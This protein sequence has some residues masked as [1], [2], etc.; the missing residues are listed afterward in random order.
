MRSGGD[1]L[2]LGHNIEQA[3]SEIR[4]DLSVGIEPHLAADRPK[5][6][7]AAVDDFMEALW[8]AIGIMLAVSFIRLGV[9][10]GAVVACSIPLV[11]A[12]VFVGM[13]F[14]GIDLQ[15]VSLG[16]LIIALGLLVDD[17]A[18][19]GRAL[20]PGL[21]A[22]LAVR[23]EQDRPPTRPTHTPIVALVRALAAPVQDISRSIRI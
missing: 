15:R 18:P 22:A 8:E 17:P 13:E 10:A 19:T 2:A 16:A 3:M 9:R 12:A 6:V 21:A 7:K 1:V 11:L 14:A 23:A 20:P 5:V 4:T